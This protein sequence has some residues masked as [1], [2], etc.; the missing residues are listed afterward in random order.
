MYLNFFIYAVS[1]PTPSVTY[2]SNPLAGEPLTVTCSF[3]L[4]PS[5]DTHIESRVTWRVNGS[6]VNLNDNMISNEDNSLTFSSVTTSDTGFYA[7]TLTLTSETPYVAVRGGPKQSAWD[8]ITVKR[9]CFFVT[10]IPQ[11]CPD[12]PFSPSA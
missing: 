5:V 8:M 1:I 3:T 12:S 9:R 6:A 7:C 10:V 4:H 2:G 11:C